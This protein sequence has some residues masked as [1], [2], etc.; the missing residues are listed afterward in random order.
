M[1]SCSLV[2]KLNQPWCA[3]DNWPGRAHAIL[4]CSNTRWASQ[5]LTLLV[6]LVRLSVHLAPT[7]QKA[8]QVAYAGLTPYWPDPLVARGSGWRDYNELQQISTP[9]Q[10]NVK[11]IL[12]MG[13]VV[14]CCT[15]CTSVSLPS[16]LWLMFT[17]CC[18]VHETTET[19]H[20]DIL[21]IIRGSKRL[22]NLTRSEAQ[23]TPRY[24]Y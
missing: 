19:L 4:V 7:Q 3:C 11:Q 23:Y 14:K 22:S 1:H 6:Q 16:Y 21:A 15:L 12:C 13:G 17:K 24:W 18:V 9:R 10:V 20:A 8:E 2:L 5:T